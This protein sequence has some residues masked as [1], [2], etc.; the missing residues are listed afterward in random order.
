MKQE[1]DVFK[2]KGTITSYQTDLDNNEIPGTRKMDHNTIQTDLKQYLAKCLAATTDFSLNNLFVSETPA[3]GKDGI[4]YHDIGIMSIIKTFITLLNDGGDGS[5]VYTEFYGYIE[6]PETLTGTL[7]LG[8]NLGS[9]PAY[10]FAEVFATY[11]ISESVAS[12]RRYHFY[13]K[14]TIG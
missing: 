13:W 5:E 1:G 7:Q 11:A 2:L 6:G 4:G 10:E 3:T 8:F 9:G 14:I 12:N